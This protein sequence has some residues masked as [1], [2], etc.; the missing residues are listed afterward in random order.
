MATADNA[1]DGAALLIAYDGSDDAGRAIAAA[2][3]A[4][5]DGR[6]AVVATVWRSIA[7]AASSAALG[8]PRDIAAGGIERLDE[9]ASTEAERCAEEGARLAREAGFEAEPRAQP[10]DSNVWST[11]AALGEEMDA[12]VIVVGARGRSAIASAVL[13]SVSHGLVG[14]AG[15]PVLVVHDRGG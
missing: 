12:A 11:L 15:R 2:G 9:A 7:E 4:M 3:R 8:L 6:R 5:G 13:G 14:H 10:A 1:P